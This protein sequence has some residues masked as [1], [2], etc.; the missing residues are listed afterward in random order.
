MK[1]FLKILLLAALV[2]V[3]IKISPILFGAAAAGLLVACLLG[4]AGLSLLVVLLAV[5]LGLAVALSP[6]WIPVLAAL[7]L[8]SLFRRTDRTPP[9][10]AA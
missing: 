2:I 10:V 8:I 6:I 3:A 9:P 5:A 4:V 7:G 1:T